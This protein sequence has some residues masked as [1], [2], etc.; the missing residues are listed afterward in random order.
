MIIRRI[1]RF[2]SRQTMDGNVN[3]KMSSDAIAS[4]SFLSKVV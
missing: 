2:P 3:D 4:Y 1:F